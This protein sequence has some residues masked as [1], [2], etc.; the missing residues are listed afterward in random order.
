MTTIQ[1]RRDAIALVSWLQTFPE[2]MTPIVPIDND[3]DD[4]SFEQILTQLSLPEVALY[5]LHDVTFCV[6]NIFVHVA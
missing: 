5:V 2:V 1:I 3:D 6:N 4:E